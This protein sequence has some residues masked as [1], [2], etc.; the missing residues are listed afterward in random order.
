[1]SGARPTEIKLHRASR[2]LEVA[3]DDGARY[4]LPCELLRVYSPSAEV[5]GHGPGQRVL[6]VGKAQVNIVGIEPVGNYAVLLRFDD[7]HQTG[8]YSWETLRD[9]GAHRERYWQQYLGELEAAGASRE[10]RA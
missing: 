6:Q 10:A 1:M 2:L 4:E 9:L 5:K 3:F 7:G 8:I